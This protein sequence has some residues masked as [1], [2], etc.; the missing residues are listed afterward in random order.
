MKKRL[1]ALAMTLALTFGMMILPASAA[2]Y[3]VK[4]LEGGPNCSFVLTN[5]GTLYACGLNQQGILGPDAGEH[6]SPQGGLVA[7]TLTKLAEDVKEVAA[8]ETP[9][10]HYYKT[11][12]SRAFT[13]WF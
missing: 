13:S 4:Q 1:L 2:D 5:D 3:S 6:T 12:T 11:P 8:S 9:T 10:L 7:T